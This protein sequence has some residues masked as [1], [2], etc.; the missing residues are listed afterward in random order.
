MSPVARPVGTPSAAAWVAGRAAARPAVWGRDL[1]CAG[2]R[3][4]RRRLGCRP[5]APLTTPP[6]LPGRWSALLQGD[7]KGGGRGLSEMKGAGRA[8]GR[9]KAKRWRTATVPGEGER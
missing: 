1:V 9:K 6:Q 7:N 3:P 5:S 8:C 4:A 2:Q